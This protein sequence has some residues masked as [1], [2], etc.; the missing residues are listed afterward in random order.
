MQ[1][2]WRRRGY[3]ENL[4]TQS[5]KGR[6]LYDW[7]DAFIIYLMRQM[8]EGGCELSRAQL[9]AATIYED[10][11]SYAIEARFPGKVAPRCRYHHFFKDPR[12]RVEDG[13]WV[14]RPFNSLESGKIRSVGFLVDCSG[15]ANDLPGKFDLAIA[16]L[17][18]SIE[19]DIEGR[20]G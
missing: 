1:R 5:D 18:N 11:L 6:W 14:A 3:I 9:F 17:N 19:R 2:D 7:Y 15:L 4:G 12:G 13:N 8:Y 16:S 10:V 20:K